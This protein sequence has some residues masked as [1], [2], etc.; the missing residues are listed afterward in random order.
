MLL[1]PSEFPD[2][3]SKVQPAAEHM[4][5]FQPVMALAAAAHKEQA[6]VLPWS[7]RRS[8]SLSTWPKLLGCWHNLGNWKCLLSGEQPTLH[9][10][11]KTGSNYLSSGHSSVLHCGQMAGPLCCLNFAFL[12][13]R[14][15]LSLSLKRWG[16]NVIKA[17]ARLSWCFTGKFALITSAERKW[18]ISRSLLKYPA[19]IC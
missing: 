2:S 19:F 3:S 9:P 4:L 10:C 6:V 1:S 13:W 18:E 11:R 7:G 17:R 15:T 12:L 5:H 8:H 14:C 16:G